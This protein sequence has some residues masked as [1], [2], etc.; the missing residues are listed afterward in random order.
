MTTKRP[1][2]LTESCPPWCHADHV[3][4]D[5]PDDR[6][7]QSRQILVPVVEPSGRAHGGA[8]ASHTRNV[9]ISEFAVVALRPVGETAVTWI[10][11]VGERQF[12]EIPRESAARLD[13]ALG[14]ILGEVR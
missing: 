4:Q 5:H 1:P 6:Y 2:W 11:V 12:V 14:E 7:H 9:E 13:A 8:D 3:D 10:A